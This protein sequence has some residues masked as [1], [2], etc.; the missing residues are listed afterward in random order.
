[1]DAFKRA[2]AKKIGTLE[3]FYLV[4]ELSNKISAYQNRVY[5]ML[6]TQQK[7]L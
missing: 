5:R 3:E 6:D 7:V 4:K 2:E 1:M